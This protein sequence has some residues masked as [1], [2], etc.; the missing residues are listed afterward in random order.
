MILSLEQIFG[1]G[2]VEDLLW[3][4]KLP[5]DLGVKFGKDDGWFLGKRVSDDAALQAWN[6][7]FGR[8]FG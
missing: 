2:T 1:T 8:N 6:A 4:R 5:V 7:Y 3:V